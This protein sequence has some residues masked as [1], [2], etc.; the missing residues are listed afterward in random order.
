MSAALMSHFHQSAASELALDEGRAMR[1]PAE[2]QVRWLQV[3]TGRVWLTHSAQS[4]QEVPRDCWL[5]AGDSVQLPAGEDAVLEAWPTARFTV[6]ASP[7]VA[8][9]SASVALRPSAAL[10]RWVQALRPVASPAPC[11]PCAS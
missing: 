6:T 11:A 1:L 2:G 3:T 9:V 5:E 8:E 7:A 4:P 10:R